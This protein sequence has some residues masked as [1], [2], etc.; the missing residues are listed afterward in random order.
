MTPG[1]IVHHNSVIA[2][3]NGMHEKHSND[4]KNLMEELPSLIKHLR[5]VM[6]VSMVLSVVQVV[7][8]FLK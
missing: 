6:C 5:I 7:V 8:L 2:S 3:L 1:E 4:M